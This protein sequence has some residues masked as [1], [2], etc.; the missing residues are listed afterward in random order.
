MPSP[1]A[2]YLL[3]S[4][5]VDQNNP[6]APTIIADVRTGFPP[7]ARPVAFPVDNAYSID[8]PSSQAFDRFMEVGMYLTLK[9]QQHGGV[10]R[11]VLQLCRVDEFAQG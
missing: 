2:P 6:N 7:N 11:W 1:K 3:V 9:D 5:D 4:F 10:V 8:V